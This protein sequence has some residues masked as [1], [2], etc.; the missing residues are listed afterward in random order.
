VPRSNTPIPATSWPGRVTALIL[1]TGLALGLVVPK[2]AGGVFLLLALMGII[3]LEPGL[4]RRRLELDSHERLLV[5]SVLAFVGVWLLSWLVHGLGP[6]GGDDVG[7][8]LRLLL[9]IPAYLFLARVDGLERGWWSG[10]AAGA[11]IAG[12]Y[13][14]AFALAGEPSGW[15][16]RVE[17]PTNPIYFGGITLAFSLMLLPR[18]ADPETAM[19]E[20]VMMAG[21]VILGLTASAISGSRGAWLALIPMLMVYLF[22]LGSRQT[23]AWRFGVP[24]ALL[25]VAA[26]LTLL[27]GVPLGH[28]IV[29]AFESF[30]A[31]GD[32]ILRDDTLAVRWAMWQL[33]FEQL[34]EAWIFGLGPDGFRAALEKAVAQGRLPD[35]F[36]EY[37]HPHNQ[38]ISAA[39]IAGVPGLLTLVLLFGV[40]IRRFALLWQTGLQRTR[41]IGWSGLAAI[42]VVVVMSLSESI[43]QRNS[44]IVWFALFMAAGHALVRVRRR[45]EL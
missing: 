5:F 21:A 13:A 34:R 14:I 27:P 23:T 16:D 35:W 40:S 24:L 2:V 25:L 44:G 6:I 4:A 26:T 20:R 37:H 8:I 11:A 12:I 43:F 41:L 22:T 42:S 45:A 39:L 38:F 19:G 1:F 3:W 15:A 7:R 32:E 29:E 10:L 28:R 30:S 18:V 33:S 36:L 31:S 9:I 17:G